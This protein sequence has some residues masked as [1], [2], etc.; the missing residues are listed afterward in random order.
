MAAEK[1]AEA[2]RMFREN[3]MQ[4]Q[5]Q[6]QQQQ[7]RQRPACAVHPKYGSQCPSCDRTFRDI[8]VLTTDAQ[9]KHV[10][11]CMAAGFM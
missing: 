3:Q 9:N 10:N 6:Q 5:Q 1:K 7:Q 11:D 2:Q 8:G 4:Q